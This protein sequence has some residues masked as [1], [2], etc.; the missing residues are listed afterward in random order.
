MVLKFKRL[1]LGL[2][3]DL[4]SSSIITSVSLK[5]CSQTNSEDPDEIG[6]TLLAKTKMILQTFI[7]KYIL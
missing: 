6:S 7:W 3:T 2:V 4:K 1:T 5:M